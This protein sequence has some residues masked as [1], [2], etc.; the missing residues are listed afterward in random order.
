MD[1]PGYRLP[2]PPPLRKVHEVLAAIKASAK[3]II[4]CGG[5]VVASSAA[6]EL[7]EF[8]AKTGIPVAMTVHGLGPSQRTLPL[9][10]HAGDATG[11]FTRITP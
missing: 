10:Q 3:P 5:G 11:P 1:L 7:R 2:P 4:Y 6:E 8:A 9:A